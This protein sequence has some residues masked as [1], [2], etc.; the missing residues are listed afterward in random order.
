MTILPQLERDL[1]D[2]AAKRVPAGDDRSLGG[3]GRIGT[4][5]RAR[6]V[7]FQ[8]SLRVTIAPL[9][10]LASVLVTVVVLAL[11]LT[12]AGQRHQR[13]SASAPGVQAARAQLI[14]HF[15]VL[16][17]PQTKADLDPTF[18]SRGILAPPLGPERALVRWGYPK[19]DRP[20]VRVI[21]IPAWHA[22]VAL[23]PVT[24]QPSPSSPRRSEGLDLELWVGTARTIPPSSD[25]GTGP[26]PTS[27][28]TLLAHGL[29]LTSAPRGRGF[30]DG[31]VVVPDGVAS[32]RLGPIR[33]VRE[34]V[35]VDPSQFGI[36]TAT[37]RN[38][39]AAFQIPMPTVVLSHSKYSMTFAG[40]GIAQ[41]TWFDAGGKPIKRTTTELDLFIKVIGKGPLPRPPRAAVLR[42]RFCRRNPHDC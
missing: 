42:S 4:S 20:L 31:V 27:I 7:R 6:W 26:R 38:N 33:L 8:R 9:P 34:P 25:D 24:F 28:G 41:A 1:F 17:R 14:A 39:I 32:I 19:L 35:T 36:F 5:A 22:K 3:A 37:V 13:T 12:L 15:G 2:A 21:H 40:G 30:I 16:R 10:T 11:A 18:V 29:G 23:E